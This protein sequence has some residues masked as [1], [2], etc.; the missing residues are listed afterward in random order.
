MDMKKSNIRELEEAKSKGGKLIGNRLD[1][2]PNT[3]FSKGRGG[4]NGNNDTDF[5]IQGKT[6]NKPVTV[7]LGKILAK[8]EIS[9]INNMFKVII[10]N[11]K[12]NNTYKFKIGEI[13]FTLPKY[14]WFIEKHFILYKNEEIQELYSIIQQLMMIGVND[15]GRYQTGENSGFINHMSTALSSVHLFHHEGNKDI[16]G[17]LMKKKIT[18]Y[19]TFMK[20]LY[21]G[22]II[23]YDDIVNI[24]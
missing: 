9:T 20:R 2:E 24:I 13:S 5:I 11:A 12:I 4:K 8:Y 19:D 23:R 18:D 21:D 17:L 22:N 16:K 6:G 10:N 3:N 7:E 1:M 15:N 14:L